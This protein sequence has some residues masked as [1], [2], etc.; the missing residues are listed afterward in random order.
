MKLSLFTG[1]FYG[2]GTAQ[3]FM[4]FYHAMNMPYLASDLL[5]NGFLSSQI[6][7]AVSTAINVAN[8]S[9]IDVRKH[10]KPIF[11]GTG[12]GIVK[13]CKLSKLGYGL[14]LMNADLSISAVSKFQVDVLQGF[15]KAT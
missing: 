13:D 10:F 2:S 14:V 3:D 7:A 8:A 5:T 12:Q 1:T 11:S 15:L 6:S 9:G 4:D